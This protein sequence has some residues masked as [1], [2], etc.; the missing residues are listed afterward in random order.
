MRFLLI[1][2]NPIDLLVTEKVLQNFD[3][4]IRV[5]KVRSGPEALSW[6]EEQGEDFPDYIF[7][8]IRMPLMDGFQFLNEIRDRFPSLADERRV[9]M[10][11]SSIDPLDISR[12]E[13][14]PAVNCFMEKPLKQSRL[15]E[16]LK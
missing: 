16:L 4:R 14:D 13:E 7:L 3:Q 1:D 12:S 9:V 6:L 8:D 10:L 2:D 11:S 15:G 5:Q